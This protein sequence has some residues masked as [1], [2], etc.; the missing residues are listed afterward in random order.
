MNSQPVCIGNDFG[1]SRHY[2]H[3]TEDKWITLGVSTLERWYYKELS[4]EDPIK[5]LDRKLRS[6]AGKTKT[7]SPQLLVSLQRQ[8]QYY[9]DRSYQL[10]SDNLSALVE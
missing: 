7:M 6:D 4:A 2:R 8:Y 3:P 10:H 5:A 9:P 1:A